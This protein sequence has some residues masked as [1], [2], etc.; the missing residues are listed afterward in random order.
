MGVHPGYHTFGDRNALASEVAYLRE[1]L[2][3]K[4]LG[5]RQHYLRW[6]P[7]TWHDW[8][9]CGLAY[10][11]SVGFA[12]ALGFR[13]GTA[14]P[15]RPWSLRENRELDLIEVPLI[16]MDCT[17]VKYMR[18]CRTE[19]LAR[20][21]QLVSRISRVGGVFTLLWH[22]TPLMDP[23]YDG[24]YTSILDLISGAPAAHL[25]SRASGLW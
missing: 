24:W 17:P 12:D 2:G 3:S 14:F 6:S 10:D 15:Y 4:S 7:Q 19:G 21:R 16:L 1:T 11:S 13:A 8:E 9:A 22:N 18:L 23:E 20:I 25:P 5:G